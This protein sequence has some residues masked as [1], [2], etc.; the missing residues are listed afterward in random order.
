MRINYHFSINYFSILTFYK[1]LYLQNIFYMLNVYICVNVRYAYQCT[2]T[3]VCASVSVRAFTHICTYI[4]CVSYLTSNNRCYCN[5]NIALHC[6]RYNRIYCVTSNISLTST[7]VL[8][9]SHGFV[10]KYQHK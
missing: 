6:L 2:H 10:T 1:I 5:E 9:M 4:C 3:C 8:R 7:L